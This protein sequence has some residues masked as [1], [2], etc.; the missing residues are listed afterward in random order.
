MVCLQNAWN[1]VYTHW[2]FGIDFYAFWMNTRGE[3]RLAPQTITFEKIC[4]RSV[5]CLPWQISFIVN[6]YHRSFCV[7]RNGCNRNE[8]P[9][10]KTI[11]MF[12]CGYCSN[13]FFSNFFIF[14]D[15]LF[16]TSQIPCNWIVRFRTDIVFIELQSNKSDYMIFVNDN[17]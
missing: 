16:A 12:L 4:N 8:F 9:P 11:I 14:R 10:K 13:I 1:L 7:L 15:F 17:F 5:V 6:T 2:N 3:F